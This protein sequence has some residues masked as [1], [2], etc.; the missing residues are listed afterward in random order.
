MF[1]QVTACAPTRI[2]FGGGWTDVPPYCD[3]EGGFVC[4][5]AID[6]WA[7]VRV[8]EASST[9]AAV[10]G[11]DRTADHSLADAALR[12]SGVTGVDILVEN[13]FPVGAGLGGS[14]AAGVAAV[15][16]L[17]A[18]R[19]EMLA[20]GEVAER[21][22]A[23]EVEDLGIP[24]GRQDHYAA[25]LGGLLGLRFTDTVEVERIELPPA[26]RREL[27]RRCILVYTGQ[28]RLSG[29]TITAVLDAYRAGDA[30]VV[31]ALKRMRELAE[32]MASALRNENVDA[33]AA[34]VG[35][36]WAHQRSL[37]PRIPTA[38]IDAIIHAAR[39]AGSRGAKALGASGGGTV[40]V[41][42]GQE[43]VDQLRAAVAPLGTILEFS[44][45]EVGLQ[46]RR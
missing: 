43:T 44:L 24:G 17:G 42:A 4:N 7:S 39:L 10:I 45:T 25:V 19:G 46:V 8:R 26:L 36:H 31:F 15:A 32:D 23:V 1:R 41:I 3:L 38:R 18:W 21:S 13:E 27:E 34:F 22:R 35:E 11:A 20:A 14:S 9:A 28:S 33:L 6:R 29:Q 40:L 37:H 16:A 2:D 30:R 12:R 5:V